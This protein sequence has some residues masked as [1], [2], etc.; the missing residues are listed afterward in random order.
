MEGVDLPV[1][2]LHTVL[3]PGQRMELR[4]FEPRYLAM[5][6]EVLPHEPF[7]IVAIREGSEVGGDYLAERVGVTVRS[8]HHEQLDDG[9]FMI[10]VAAAER[11]ALLEQVARS[12]Y[13]AWAVEVFPDEGG[14]GTDDLEAALAAAVAYLAAAGETVTGPAVPHDPVRASWALAAATPGM[15]HERQ[16]LLAT[17]GAGARLRSIRDTFRRE[18]AM[19]PSVGVSVGGTRFDISPN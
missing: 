11:V 7:V 13:P 2:A 18:A 4:V 8:E 16:A 5:M 19:L 1:F 12:P 15:V 9:T 6:D 17:P 10:R 3:F 14:A